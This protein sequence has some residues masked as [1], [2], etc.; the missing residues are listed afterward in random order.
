MDNSL[1]EKDKWIY[2]RKDLYIL[3][4]KLICELNRMEKI[5]TKSRETYL[6]IKK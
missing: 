2:S 1:S 6:V 5:E 4:F 3:N